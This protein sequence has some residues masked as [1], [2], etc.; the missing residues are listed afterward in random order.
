M[1][2]SL[3]T[4]SVL[5][6]LITRRVQKV[7]RWL[8]LPLTAW[9]LILI[10]FDSYIFVFVTA[11]FKDLGINES[12]TICDGAILLCEYM[13]SPLSRGVITDESRSCLLHELEDINILLFGRESGRSSYASP[14][15]RDAYRTPNST[16]YED[17]GCRDCRT[18]YTCS[19]ALACCCLTPS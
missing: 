17:R 8:A 5:S 4:L 14:V 1:I 3:L 13:T 10:Y 18:H 11:M 6:I 9:L 7:G 15:W 16:S 2:L 12:E 19:T